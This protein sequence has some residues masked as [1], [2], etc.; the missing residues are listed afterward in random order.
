MGSS[1]CRW[2]SRSKSCRV[3]HCQLLWRPAPEHCNWYTWPNR[4]QSGW[5]FRLFES[6]ASHPQWRLFLDEN[7][8]MW[9]NTKERG[10]WSSCIYY[11]KG[12]PKFWEKGKSSKYKITWRYQIRIHM[13]QRYP[14]AF[15][16][17]SGVLPRQGIPAQLQIVWCEWCALDA[18][19]EAVRHWEIQ[20]TKQSFVSS[21]YFFSHHR[22]QRTHRMEYYIRT[23]FQCGR[24]DGVTHRRGPYV[25]VCLN[26]NFIRSERY[27]TTDEKLLESLLLPL[28]RAKLILF[29][30][31]GKKMKRE[32]MEK[33]T[34]TSTQKLCVPLASCTSIKSS[35][36]T[37]YTS[38]KSE[39]TRRDS[40]LEEG[41][42]FSPSFLPSCLLNLFAL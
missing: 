39:T 24:N 13:F 37:L 38:K 25:V 20:E 23:I 2:A 26:N 36:A 10:K 18:F 9:A 32:K 21:L 15:D 8:K 40:I 30:F 12:Q 16:E 33:I 19:W 27:K 28:D 7:Q 11:N 1:Y 31:P 22:E 6:T 41:A 4:W 17:T 35:C 5:S 42:S 29:P 34:F 14:V 3:A